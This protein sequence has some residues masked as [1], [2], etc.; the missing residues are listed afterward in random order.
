M[1]RTLA[2]L[3]T[4]GAFLVPA[5]AASAEE[6]VAPTPTHLNA[7]CSNGQGGNYGHQT[8]HGYN[9]LGNTARAGACATPASEKVT[10]WDKNHKVSTDTS[11]DDDDDE[12]SGGLV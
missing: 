11:P 8:T 1:R 2:V 12:G 10:G 3:V 4:A 5:G 9:K 6:V 7:S